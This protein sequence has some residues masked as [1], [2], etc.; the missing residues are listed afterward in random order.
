MHYVFERFMSSVVN[1]ITCNTTIA[2][3]PIMV[4]TIQIHISGITDI[5]ISREKYT[6]ATHHQ[7]ADL[8]TI[9]DANK[10]V[11]M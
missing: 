11:Q 7:N 6:K 4:V 3:I 2:W 9:A 1:V 5:N 8:I 10:S